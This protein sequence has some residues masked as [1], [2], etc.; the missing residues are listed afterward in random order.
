MEMS[1]SNDRWCDGARPDEALAEILHR[2]G[3]N[4]VVAVAGRTPPIKA[5]R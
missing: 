4:G 2:V 3:T 5:A 1:E